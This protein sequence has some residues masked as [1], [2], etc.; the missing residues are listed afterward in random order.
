MPADGRESVRGE[1]GLVFF[2]RQIVRARSLDNAETKIFRLLQTLLRA[3]REDSAQTVKLKSDGAGKI[4]RS[5][6]VLRDGGGTHEG[7]D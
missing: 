2:R 6:S 3:L 5:P 7:G 4:R 1:H